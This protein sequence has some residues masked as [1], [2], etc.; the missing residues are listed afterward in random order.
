MRRLLLIASL[1]IATNSY[2][3]NYF[4][5]QSSIDSS[6]HATISGR[7]KAVFSRFGFWFDTAVSMDMWTDLMRSDPPQST[8]QINYAA[9]KD[10]I[11]YAQCM[12]YIQDKWDWYKRCRPVVQMQ[13]MQ[14][15]K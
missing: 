2:A 3:N 10:T 12:A 11:K 9:N 1:L 7:A 15:K 6:C 8:C 4:E 13:V 14:D 5:W